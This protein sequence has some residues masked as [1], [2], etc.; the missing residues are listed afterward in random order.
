MKK[1]QV[2][3]IP[4]GQASGYVWKWRSA[5]GNAGSSQSFELYYDC[6]CDARSHGYEVDLTYAVGATAPGGADYN[7]RHMGEQS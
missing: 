3:T 7:L 5:E 2:Y 4:A 6:V 1:A